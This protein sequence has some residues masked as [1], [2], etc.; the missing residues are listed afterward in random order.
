MRSMVYMTHLSSPMVKELQLKVSSQ[1]PASR[2]IE[3][4]TQS[5]GAIG[6][7]HWSIQLA[8]VHGG[9]V[10]IDRLI[11]PVWPIDP[12]IDSR[13]LYSRQNATGSIGWSIQEFTVC[14]T[15][16]PID[17]LIDWGASNRSADRSGFLISYQKSD[18]STVSC[19]IHIQRF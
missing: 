3:L 1:N 5:I 19:P 11:D 8:T 16:C 18:F 10:W 12:M 14:G 15:T 9:P 4:I 7:I 17:P 6:S 2:S 13:A